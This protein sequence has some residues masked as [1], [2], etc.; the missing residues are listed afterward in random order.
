[1]LWDW[2][3]ARQHKRYVSHAGGQHIAIEAM[4]ATRRTYS[5]EISQS[6]LSVAKVSASGT[7][8]CG[9]YHIRASNRTHG[10]AVLVPS[11]P[12]QSVLSK[13]AEQAVGTEQLTS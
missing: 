6:R 5:Q 13:I 8:S 4:S 12:V 1:M 2:V 10:S 9:L 11:V 7:S 3:Q